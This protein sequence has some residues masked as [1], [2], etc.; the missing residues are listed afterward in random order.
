MSTQQT[1][2]RRWSWGTIVRLGVSVEVH[3]SDLTDKDFELGENFEGAATA[4]ARRLLS[5][6]LD[7]RQQVEGRIT[8]E[9]ERDLTS[10][11][12]DDIEEIDA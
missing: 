3:E 6:H 5:D 1:P 11:D 4:A 9:G 2:G 7:V 10:Y 8:W 12:Y